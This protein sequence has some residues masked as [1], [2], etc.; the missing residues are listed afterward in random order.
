MKTLSKLF[1][2]ASFMTFGCAT[3]R[4][5]QS[6]VSPNRGAVALHGPAV[7]AIGAG[8][9]TIHAY[10]AY[11]GGALYAVPAVSG[12]DSDC[13]RQGAS[14]ARLAL[15]ADR[16]VEFDVASGQVACLAS[17]RAGTFELLWHAA[18]RAGSML[19]QK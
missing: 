7:K 14:P 8:P 6:A 19:A 11:P 13:H 2:V 9:G 5:L 17:S 1:L 4:T 15:Q 12:T 3:G 10:S 18:P 16:I